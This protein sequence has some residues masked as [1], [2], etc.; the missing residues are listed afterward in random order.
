MTDEKKRHEEG[1]DDLEKKDPPLSREGW[2]MLLSD[3]INNLY[4]AN[5]VLASIFFACALACLAG[6]I[7][8][9]IREI[10]CPD[11]RPTTLAVFALFFIFLLLGHCLTTLKK[12]KPIERIRKGIIL[13]NEGLKT[14]SEICDHCKNAEVILKKK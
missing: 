8:L 1:K 7:A 6:I 13:E 5:L 14:F 2:I 4:M 9:M 3:E 10:V 11:Y 12:V